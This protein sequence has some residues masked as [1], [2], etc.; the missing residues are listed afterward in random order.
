MEKA[1]YTAIKAQILSMVPEC[2]FIAVW[3]NQVD[4]MQNGEDYSI[5]LPAIFVEL[6]TNT[7]CDVVGNNVR[8]FDPLIIR[9]HIVDDRLDNMDGTLEENFEVFDLKQKN[10]AAFQLFKTNG[11]SSF[12]CTNESAD[13]DHNNIYHFLQDFTT[14]WTDNQQNLPVGGYLDDGPHTTVITPVVVPIV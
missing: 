10:Y 6:P 9:F 2:K 3:N 11:S 8:V 14:T 7:P 1:L 13:E 12:N 5:P 4:K